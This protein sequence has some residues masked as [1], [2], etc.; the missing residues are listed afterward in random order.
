[1]T[2]A[3]ISG[4]TSFL[5]GSIRH[6]E[7]LSI[8]TQSTSAN[9]GAHANEVSPPAEKIAMS[10]VSS[11]AVSKPTI[12]YSLPLNKTDFP[13]LRSDATGISSVTG[14][15][16]SSNNFIIMVPTI[17]VAPTTAIFIL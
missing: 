5:V 14:K 7:E 15:F 2:F 1:M 4:T 11:T 12:L 16:R 3:F 9:F 8:T 10:G 17:P 13:T 6:A